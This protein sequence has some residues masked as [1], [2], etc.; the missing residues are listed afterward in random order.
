MGFSRR[1]RSIRAALLAAL[2][3]VLSTG[4]PSHHH[5][6]SDVGDGAVAIGPDHHSHGTILVDQGDRVASS[7]PELP[8]IVSSPLEPEA[9]Q[10]I[11]VVAAR[12]AEIRPRERA[13]PADS[14]P[15]A[16]PHLS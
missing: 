13:P 12:E 5:E 10:V 11:R 1:V 9:P 7:T 8:V 2:L 6:R 16:P 3:A 14:S 4:V 15:R